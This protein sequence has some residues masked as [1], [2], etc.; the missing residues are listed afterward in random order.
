MDFAVPEA[1]DTGHR[2]VVFKIDH[3]CANLNAALVSGIQEPV[4]HRVEM[5]APRKLP[6]RGYRSGGNTS[7]RPLLV[8]AG[9]LED[10]WSPD[11]EHATGNRRPR[12]H[13]PALSRK[14]HNAP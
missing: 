5:K 8:F 3:V 11:W 4:R 1:N 13:T 12:Y 2:T 7:N 9:R 14:H 10:E 6:D